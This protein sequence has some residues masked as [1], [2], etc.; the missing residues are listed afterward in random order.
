M[1]SSTTTARP[2]SSEASRST[3][4][5]I[6]QSWSPAGSS[7]AWRD[8]PRRRPPRRPGTGPAPRAV[9]AD[10]DRR[11]AAPSTGPWP[12]PA[13]RPSRR[14]P[15]SR[16]ARLRVRPAGQQLD[17]PEHLVAHHHPERPPV[18]GD[19]PGSAAPTP[20]PPPRGGPARPRPRSSGWRS[21]L[22]LV[23]QARVD[24]ADQL[25]QPLGEVEQLVGLGVL[26][27]VLDQ[28]LVGVGQVAQ[29][30]ALRPGQPVVA[31]VVGEGHR[32]LV[33]VAGHRLGPDRVVAHPR[34]LDRRRRR[35]GRR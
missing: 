33:E 20:R 27:H 23:E 29:Q 24:L 14:C 35:T 16:S 32:P 15:T 4:A 6:A 8:A 13:R 17:P 30:Q 10:A 12:R 7:S 2:S 28:A 3:R 25:A 9:G 5:A 34:V 18:G 19:P 21:V 31:D 26:G 11:R 1:S 22:P